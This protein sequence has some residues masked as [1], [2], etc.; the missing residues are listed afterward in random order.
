MNSYEGKWIRVC[1]WSCIV[2]MV[3][4]GIGFGVL[5]HNIPP[6]SPSF[7]ATHITQL[8]REHRNTYRIGYGLG[9]FATTFYVRG[10]WAS[11]C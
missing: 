6:Y 11:F 8:Y 3:I 2:F 7:S 4:F 5:G 1:A 9:A 10:L